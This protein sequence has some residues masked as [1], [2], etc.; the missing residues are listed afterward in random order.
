MHGFSSGGED[1]PIK[2]AHLDEGTK[3]ER[4]EELMARPEQESA[5]RPGVLGEDLLSP[6]HQRR[7]RPEGSDEVRPGACRDCK[8]HEI[9]RVRRTCRGSRLGLPATS[10]F[11]HTPHDTLPSA[12]RR[13]KHPPSQRSRHVPFLIG[14]WP[15]GEGII[16]DPT[17]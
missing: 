15:T 5:V 2:E 6:N 9:S 8:D 17:K 11:I 3:W 1:R 4:V 14:P 10:G 12:M 7:L 16:H 13:A